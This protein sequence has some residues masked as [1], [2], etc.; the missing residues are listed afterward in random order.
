M[1][2]L[3]RPV[4]IG[5]VNATGAPLN[6]THGGHLPTFGPVLYAPGAACNVIAQATCEARSY[7]VRMD[8]GADKRAVYTVHTPTSQMTFR[9]LPGC[10]T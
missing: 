2:L 1:Y 7:L 9:L 5:G 3:Q 8:H 6:V 10:T 4:I